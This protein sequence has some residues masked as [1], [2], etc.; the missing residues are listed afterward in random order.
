ME[1]HYRMGWLVVMFDLPVTTKDER[2]E[3][4]NFRK[5]LLDDGYMMIQFSVYARD[6]VSYEHYEKHI[7]RLEPIV[8]QG[9]NVKVFYLTDAQW[10][11]MITVAGK[12]DYYGKKW[13]TKNP[14]L[15]QQMTFWDDI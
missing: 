3:A 13:K 12:D 14:E 11:K 6:C 10:G 9:G 2:K 8:P 1:S 4:S 15:P 7:Q 5:N